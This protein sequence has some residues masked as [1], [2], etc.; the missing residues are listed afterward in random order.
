MN[1]QYPQLNLK[2]YINKRLLTIDK[3][4]EKRLNMPESNAILQRGCPVFTLAGHPCDIR[5]RTGVCIRFS[6]GRKNPHRRL[7]RWHSLQEPV[8]PHS[9]GSNASEIRFSAS[10]ISV[11]L[12][13]HFCTYVVFTIQIYLG[14][15]FSY[16]IKE[17]LVKF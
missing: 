5:R 9:S 13:I 8:F 1:P 16:C 17:F 10:Q 6:S 4:Y 7:Q 15:L 11:L 12:F 2:K 14:F 3:I